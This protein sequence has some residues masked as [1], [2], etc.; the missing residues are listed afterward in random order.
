[1][2]SI[3]AGRLASWVVLIS[4]V[5]L[6]C[7]PALVPEV[8][9][10]GAHELEPV[11][12]AA[13]AAVRQLG[14][15]AAS[16]WAIGPADGDRPTGRAT[17]VS[18]SF[19]GFGVDRTVRLS[20][21]DGDGTDGHGLDTSMLLAG[22]ARELA[23][24]AQRVSI[25]P[26]VVARDATPSGCA[27]VA[28]SLTDEWATVAEPVALLVIGDGA[29][30]LTDRAPGGGVEPDA[31]ALQAEIDAALAGGDPRR[32]RALDWDRC[33][34]WGVGGRAA[35]EVAAACAPGPATVRLDYAGAPLGVGYTVA[36]WRFE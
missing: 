20:G 35:W 23:A 36:T 25:V 9:G 4:A 32:L 29:I 30:H 24:D 22:W 13:R 6:P 34:R 17:G 19:G 5:F 16:W 33:A 27:A 12:A 1:M 21:G 11:R 2:E 7:A 10:P 8:S 15:D 28:A 26:T 14:G 31:V 3:Q 18:G